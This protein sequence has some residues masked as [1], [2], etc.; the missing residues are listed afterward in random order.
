MSKVELD[1][2]TAVILSAIHHRLRGK[3]KWYQLDQNRLCMPGLQLG[4]VVNLDLAIIEL[5]RIGCRNLRRGRRYLA[6]GQ[7]DTAE[8][9]LLDISLCDQECFDM[10]FAAIEKHAVVAPTAREAAKQLR[11]TMS[12]RAIPPTIKIEA[13]CIVVKRWPPHLQFP[14]D[15]STGWMG[16]PARI[17]YLR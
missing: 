10:L 5:W 8:R 4:I 1:P 12:Q 14:L 16:Y 3:H 7:V 11:F 9:K 17:E 2:M 6:F 13:G 15:L